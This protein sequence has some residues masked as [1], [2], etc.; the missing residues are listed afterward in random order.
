[1]VRSLLPLVMIGGSIVAGEAVREEEPR[2]P[3]NIC[4]LDRIY[5][6]QD[7]FEYCVSRN[8]LESLLSGK[9][10]DNPIEYT[11]EESIKLQEDINE[12]FQKIMSTNPVRE[13]VA[14]ITA[15]T[16]GC[17]KTQKLQQDFQKNLSEN[18][19]RYAYIYPSDVS[20]LDQTRTYKADLEKSDGSIEARKKAYDK[21]R[22]GS[23]AAMHLIIANLIKEKYAF[24]FGTTS[25][26]P[27]TGK[28]FELLKKQGYRIKLIHISAPDEVRWASIQERDTIFIKKSEEDIKEKG[29]LI[30]QRTGDTYLKYA[31]EIEFYYKGDVKQDPILAARW[32]KSED[33]AQA[34]GT[35]QIIDRAH[36]EKIKAL[37]NAAIEPLKTPDLLW[38]EAV[39]G[40]SKIIFGLVHSSNTY[41]N[42]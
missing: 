7:G 24:Y 38:E 8:I 29:L 15:G 10:L 30:P 35:L 36:Y 19:V 20:L 42:L 33:S 28:F 23:T 26:S 11:Q 3:Y 1:M 5:D 22:P 18:K 6:S 9:A 17:G 40:K 21:W 16:P 4:D 2:V 34:K 25:A 14:I 39:E 31:D 12:T 27:A 37:H 13:Q 41:P 32:K